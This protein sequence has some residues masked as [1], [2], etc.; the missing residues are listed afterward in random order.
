VTQ[1]LHQL[2]HARQEHYTQIWNRSF[3]IFLD[4]LLFG[5]GPNNF[6]KKCPE[7][8][9]GP[10]DNIEARCGL[11]PHNFYLEIAVETGIVGLFIILILLL[12]WIYRMAKTYK[13]WQNMPVHIGLVS[14]FV[15]SFVPLLPTRSFFNNWRMALLWFIIGWLMASLKAIEKN[16]GEIR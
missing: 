2:S 5:V 11:H 16:K 7:E 10:V 6:R 15:I 14:C 3:R 12:T 4:V 13:I 1:T 9:Y 8:R